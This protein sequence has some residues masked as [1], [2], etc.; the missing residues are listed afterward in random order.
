MARSARGNPDERFLAQLVMRESDRLSRLLSEFLAFSRVRVTRARQLDFSLVAALAADVVR[1][2][3]DCPAGA[4]IDVTG[5][6][7]F[8]E[9]DEDVMAGTTQDKPGHDGEN[10]IKPKSA[11][12]P[13]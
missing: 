4:E 9:G 13:A 11:A 1:N 2:H 7:I 6:S 12:R 10:F 8:L 5:G 3:P